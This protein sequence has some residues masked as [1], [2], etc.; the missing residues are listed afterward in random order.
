MFFSSVN[1]KDTNHFLLANMDKKATFIVYFYILRIWMRKRILSFGVITLSTLFIGIHTTHAGYTNASE[2]IT[3][4]IAL[5]KS[6][7][8]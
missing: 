7:A 2:A 3:D 5:S 6:I 4:A 1:R 8:S